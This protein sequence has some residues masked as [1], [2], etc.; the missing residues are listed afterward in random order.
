MPRQ[1]HH[2]ASPAESWVNHSGTP[3]TIHTNCWSHST[4]TAQVVPLDKWM[5]GC[6]SSLPRKWVSRK[7]GFYRAALAGLDN[8]AECYIKIMGLTEQ[9]RL[10]LMCQPGR[11][12]HTEEVRKSLEGFSED[13]RCWSSF[14]IGIYDRQQTPA[15]F[16]LF[17][18]KTSFT[19]GFLKNNKKSFIKIE[20]NSWQCLIWQNARLI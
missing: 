11:T 13:V 12:L 1:T 5:S 19:D 14:Q 10:S 4:W 17:S 2:H 8:T 18:S 9:D 15:V 7:G 6:W 16:E 20:S 3:R